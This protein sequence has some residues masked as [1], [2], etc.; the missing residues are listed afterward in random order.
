MRF[1][2]IVFFFAFRYAF[3]LYFKKVVVLKKDNYFFGRTIFVSNHQGSFMDPLLIA[4]SRRPIVFFMTRADV[5]N[6]ITRPIFWLAHMV[7]IYR[8]RDGVD[9]KKM[10]K[11]IFEKTNEILESKRNILIFGEGFT[12]DL[13]QRRLHPIKKGAARIGFSAL[14][15]DQWKNNIYLQGLGINYMDFNSRETEVLID[16]GPPICLNDFREAYLQNPAKTI[17][18]VTALLELDMR[19]LVTDIHDLQWSDFHENTM[20]F[21]RQGLHPDCYD[22]KWSISERTLYSKRLAQWLNNSNT[23]RLTQVK[24]VDDKMKAYNELLKTKGITENERY[25][26]VHENWRPLK[27]IIQMIFI[28]PLA[29]LG[30]IHAG[31]PYF[32]SKSW[33]EKSFKRPVFW[34]STKLLAGIVFCTLWNIPVLIFLPGFLPFDPWL[35]WVIAISYFLSIGIL[36]RCMLWFLQYVCNIIRFVHL[37]KLDLTEINQKHEEILTELNSLVLL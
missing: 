18:D 21:S 11:K 9:T 2:Y 14:E 8:L 12:S 32:F 22:E 36:A 15:Y 29:L 10:N 37:R 23:D 16:S 20:M 28:L 4:G 33:V 26:T 31:P 6:K 1:L 13:I 7:P 30:F 19:S 3:R 24:T 25:K 5:F 17:T 34:G 35:N 27:L